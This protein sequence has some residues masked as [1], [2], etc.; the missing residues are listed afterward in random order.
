MINNAVTIEGKN[1]KSKVLLYA[2]YIWTFILISR[3]QDFVEALISVRPALT[4]G[5]AVVILYVFYQGSYKKS[6]LFD[7]KQSRLY[8]YL[9]AVMIIS[10][11]FAYYRRGAFGFIFTQYISTVFYFVLFQKI[12]DSQ[13]KLTSILWTTC[14]GTGLYLLTAIQRGNVEGG[15]LTFGEMFDPNDLAFYALSFMPFNLLFISKNE[16]IWK[17]LASSA[18]I[19]I[20]VLTVL[21]TGS[22]GGLVA[23]AIVIIMMFAAKSSIIKTSYKLIIAVITIM[24]LLYGGAKVDLSRYETMTKISDDYNVWDETGRIAVWKRG[25]ALMLSYPIT[26]VG[27]SCFGE[28]IGQERIERGIQEIW[29]APHSSLI[30][31]GA[32]TGLVGL[33]LFLLLSFNAYRVFAKVKLVSDASH[34]WKIGEFAKIGFAGHFVTSMFLSQAYSIYWVY[35][36]ALSAVLLNMGCKTN[37]KEISNKQA[38]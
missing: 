30:Q 23:L 11:P 35:F 14:F 15:R 25:I 34:Y 9:L 18:N 8:F 28:A 1:T 12:I 37:I 5:I 7:N 38:S 19:A 21:M 10:I 31:I 27:V 32:E 3:P 26:G 36:I 20:S 33:A 22:R 24:V 2:F 4:V 29:Q 16:P 6:R 13:E 17:R